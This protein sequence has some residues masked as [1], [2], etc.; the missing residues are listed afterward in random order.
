LFSHPTRTAIILGAGF[1]KNASLPLTG[2]VSAFLLDK[3][4]T[5]RTDLIISN[6]IKKFLKYVFGW[7]KEEPIPPLEDIF[8]LI[9]LSANTGH[10]LGR[11][12]PPK[13][14]RALR[15]MLIFRVYSVLDMKFQHC[16]DID[17]L[18]RH[19]L[20][21]AGPVTTHFIVLNWDIVLE[22]HLAQ[23]RHIAVDYCVSA[24]PW[25]RTPSPSAPRVGVAKI[26]GSSNWVYCDNCHTLFF[27]L[28]TK[29]SLG[30]R[31]GLIKADFRL[32]DQSVDKQTFRSAIG[33]SSPDRA[34]RIC[35]VAV[36]P[37]IAT[38]S[39]R[40]SF[41]TQAFAS[42]WLAAERILSEAPRW[43]FV[44]YSLPPADYEFKHLLKT[45]E[46]KLKVAGN[47]PKRIDVVLLNDP[48]A[49]TAYKRFFGAHVRVHQQGLTQY[50][51]SL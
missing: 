46:L 33:L 48:L 40:K 2:E 4:F 25:H 43:L 23:L 38:F 22:Q 37:H 5:S 13:S 15:R 17:S 9:D 27:D 28:S 3:S 47:H 14:L 30:I 31:A 21:A 18:L 16:A 6:S 8:T 7:R 19:F 50:V 24:Q 45:C 49:E 1:S 10:N 44:G 20:P 35:K 29:L 26:H 34:C 39:Y 51:A 42:T 11:P 41:R 32:F 12:F 36:G